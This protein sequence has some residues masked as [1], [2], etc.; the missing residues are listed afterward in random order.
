MEGYIIDKWLEIRR[1][2]PHSPRKSK[3]LDEIETASNHNLLGS[4]LP[5]REAL[6]LALGDLESIRYTRR[7]NDKL[8]MISR[9]MTQYDVDIKSLKVSC[10]SLLCEP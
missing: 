8:D 7:D 6:Q 5:E 9:A 2:Q 3:G 4:H 10:S 1:R